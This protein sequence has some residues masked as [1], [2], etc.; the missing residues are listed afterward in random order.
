MRII[1]LA[2]AALAF[3]IAPGLASAQAWPTKTVKI[4]VPFAAGSSTDLLARLIADHMGKTQGQPFIVENKAGAGGLIG[5]ELAAKAAPDG[6]TLIMLTS[7][8]F[9][10]NPAVYA[11]LPYDPIKDFEPIANV[12]FTPQVFVV[13]PQTKFRTLKELV[14]AAKKEPGAIGA[15]SLGKGATSHLALEGFQGVAG[16]KLNHI[17]FKG[18][19][20]AQTQVLG[21]SVPM[22]SDAVPGVRAQIQGGKL[23]GLAIAS[24]KRSPFLPDVPTFAEQGY[25]GFEA[26]GWI[27][28]GAPAGTPPAILDKLQAE[29][30]KMMKE[31]AVK[32]KFDSLAFVSAL[33]TRAEFAAFIKAEIAKWSKVAKDAG[34]RAD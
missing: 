22:M 5:T 32:E 8:P 25:P 14:E 11:K 17:P 18:S 1:R 3:A 13:G 24:L 27:G 16:I 4:I 12:G 19:S 10:S 30:V 31:P 29:I 33:G 9:A 15:G 7:G 2:A 6:H 26:V 34:V 21:G 20:E 23:T 28:L